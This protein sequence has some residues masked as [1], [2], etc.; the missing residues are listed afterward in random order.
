MVI[1]HPESGHQW[2]AV[3]LRSHYHL[4]VHCHLILVSVRTSPNYQTST[5]KFVHLV[6]P[7]LVT[8]TRFLLVRL[9]GLLQVRTGVLPVNHHKWFQGHHLHLV[10]EA[11]TTVIQYRPWWSTPL[12]ISV[13]ITKHYTCR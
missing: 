2:S 10:P 9:F 7:A 5:S 8:V 11:V 12:G 6:P 1:P 3:L 4:Q 13:A